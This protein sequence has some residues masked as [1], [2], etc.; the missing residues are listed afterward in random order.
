MLNVWELGSPLSFCLE[1][2]GDA[3]VPPTDVLGGEGGVSVAYDESAPV[4]KSESAEL[5]TK[6][7]VVGGIL[8]VTGLFV[9]VELLVLVL[10]DPLVEVAWHSWEVVESWLVDSVLVL[11][12]DDQRGALLL[13]SLGMEVHASSWLHGSGVWLVLVLNSLWH[14]TTLND[15]DIEI[16]V[17]V[18]WYWLAANWGPGEGTTVGVVC[19]AVEMSFVTLME[20][21]DRKIPTVEYLTVTKSENLWSSISLRLGVGD[22]SA[23]LKSSYPMSSDPVALLTEL[24][25]SFFSDID[26]DSC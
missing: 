11:A 3:V 20:L 26:S 19:W 6:L 25:R 24:I 9:E 23:I 21:R 13:G 5:N 7:P 4:A 17:G 22:N 18:Q 8:E 14:S 12:G 1:G 15:F 10:L 16:H 2:H